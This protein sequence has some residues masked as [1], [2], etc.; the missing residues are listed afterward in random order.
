MTHVLPH[1]LDAETSVVGGILVHPKALHQVADLVAPADFYHP[2]HEAIYRAMLDL[3]ADGK[4]IDPLTLAEQMRVTDALGK[5]RGEGG[6]SYFTVLASAVVTVENVAFHARIVHEKATARRMI[7][8]AQ[9]IAARGYSEH[10]AD[11]YIDES[12]RAIFEITQ[13]AR[14][15]RGVS[16]RQAVSEAVKAIELRFE[17]K[18]LVTGVPTGFDRLDRMT[19]GF[20]PG[21]LVIIAARPSM[22]KTTLAMNAVASAAIDQ[23]IPALVFSLEMSYRA[24]T[25]RALCADGR[26]D[27][28][29]L[30]AGHLSQRDWIALT[31]AASRV[32][33][34]PIRIDDS[35][36]PT[37]LDIRA[38]AR[39][40]RADV[41]ADV[42]KAG[43]L[44]LVVVDYL[45]LI[46]PSEG[47]K[48]RNREREVAEITRGLKALA[49]ELAVPVV[50]LAQLNRDCEKRADKRPMLSDL[51]ESGAIEQ[52]ADL[53]VFLYRDEIYNKQSEH[54]GI[55]EAIVGKQRSGA[56]GTVRLAF[57]NQ[58]TRFE[59]L[60]QREEG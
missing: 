39:R 46:A 28:T 23:R 60:T 44:G 16:M 18:Q 33:E 3:D 11:G 51:R 57:L 2:A 49:K 5:L 21:D 22:G 42:E 52:D 25:E 26:I 4:P 17:R 12:E 34:A 27:S 50:V 59:N 37:L 48:E 40:W 43:G 6:E 53:I 36:S 31:R 19:A 10:D 9:E 45:Q 8:A 32:A 24:L 30:R 47:G 7:H 58:Y 1:S 35:G 14:P 41:A 20:Q 29:C 55:A 38:R 56:I 13:G 54:K 15:A